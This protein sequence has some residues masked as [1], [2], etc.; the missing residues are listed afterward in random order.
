MPTVR[1]DVYAGVVLEREFY[2]VPE[3]VKEPLLAKPPK[4]EARTPEEKQAVAHRQAQLHFCRLVNATFGALGLLAWYVTLTFFDEELPADFAT[5]KRLVRN[6][7][8]RL[9]TACPGMRA[10]ATL[11][12]GRWTG[13]IHAHLIIAGPSK[14]L[15]LSK[16]PHGNVSKA[17][18]LKKNNFYEGVDHGADYTGLACY[19]IDHWTP[20]QGGHRW[21]SCGKLEK[22]DKDK[23]SVPKAQY[24]LEKP[25]PTPKGY[26]LVGSKKTR[27]M[28]SF[29]FVRIPPGEEEDKP[30][31]LPYI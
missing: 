24:S 14:K 18:T 8:R 5:A 29:K 11:G 22:Y 12:R 9:K 1:R 26:K 23:R 31:A 30:F 7:L 16:W 15:I 3:G 4:E 21:M 13:R 2:H 25:P 27:A 20:E 28:L 10:V 17:V 6:Y 19:M